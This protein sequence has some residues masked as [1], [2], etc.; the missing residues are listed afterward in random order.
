MNNLSLRVNFTGSYKQTKKSVSV[1]M[2]FRRW[3]TL[4]LRSDIFLFLPSASK[5]SSTSVHRFNLKI[6]PKIY[7]LKGF[8]SSSFHS[9]FFF[10]QAFSSS[11]YSLLLSWNYSNKNILKFPFLIHMAQNF[12]AD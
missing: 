11:R 12:A 8:S 5:C 4:T 10:L 7:L 6:F 1:N 3:R 9:S 2:Y